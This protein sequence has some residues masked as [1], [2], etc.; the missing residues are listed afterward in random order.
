M[1]F[2]RHPKV[3]MTPKPLITMTPGEGNK[4]SHS[5]VSDIQNEFNKHC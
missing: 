2:I 4:H 5:R 3:L 1:A